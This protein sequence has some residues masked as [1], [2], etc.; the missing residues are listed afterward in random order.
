MS[1]S[2]KARRGSARIC[3]HLRAPVPRPACSGAGSLGA[4][5][6]LG[7]DLG[8]LLGGGVVGAAEDAGARVVPAAGL[9]AVA[10][11][12]HLREEDGDTDRPGDLEESRDSLERHL[13]HLGA[14]E[15]KAV[16]GEGAGHVDDHDADLPPPSDRMAEV[17]LPVHGEVAVRDD[18]GDIGGGPVEL[19]VGHEERLPKRLRPPAQRGPEAASHASRWSPGSHGRPAGR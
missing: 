10:E 3:N 18:V 5:G 16:L 6:D 12:D 9:G 17:A 19:P 14:A 7:R 11:G 8:G 1:S 2:R 4:G 15:G 13:P